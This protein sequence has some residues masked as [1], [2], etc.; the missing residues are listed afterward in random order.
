MHAAH[1]TGKEGEEKALGYLK[2]NHFNILHTN[3]RHKRA[4]VDIIAQKQNVLHF[5]EVKTRKNNDFGYPEEFVS[6]R[7]IELFHETAEHYIYEHNW[8]GGLQFDIIAITL[9]P[10]ELEYIPDCF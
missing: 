1:Q 10:E 3:F 4:E 5:I 2:A 7:K 6:D 8:I 9:N